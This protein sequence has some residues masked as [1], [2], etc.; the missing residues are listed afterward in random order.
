MTQITITKKTKLNSKTR[1]CEQ[2]SQ[3]YPL[4]LDIRKQCPGH[5]NKNLSSTL[6]QGKAMNMAYVDKYTKQMKKIHLKYI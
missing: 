6:K 3:I 1:I 5:V 2:S 4:L